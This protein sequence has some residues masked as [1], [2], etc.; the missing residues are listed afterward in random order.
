MKYVHPKEYTGIRFN[1]ER[2]QIRTRAIV[3]EYCLKCDKFMG[4]DHDFS[5]CR[6]TD[7][8][9]KGKIIKKKTCPFNNLAVSVD[10]VELQE[11]WIKCKVED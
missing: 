8:W 5:E 2:N 11:N 4:K 6:I 7:L 10:I 9:S 3:E 1:T